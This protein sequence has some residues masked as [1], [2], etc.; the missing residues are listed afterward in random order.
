[1][2]IIIQIKDIESKFMVAWRN[3]KKKKKKNFFFSKS[4]KQGWVPLLALNIRTRE[5]F[6]TISLYLWE[7]NLCHYQDR[8]PTGSPDAR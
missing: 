2:T 1:M 4:P 8:W 6:N 3:P 7:K 5:K